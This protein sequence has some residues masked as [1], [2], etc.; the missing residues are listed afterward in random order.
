M[1]ALNDPS[2]VRKR[3]KLALP[4]PVVSE[5]ELE[6]IVKMGYSAAAADA[7]GANGATRNLIGDYRFEFFFFHKVLAIVRLKNF[8]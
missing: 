7:P 3:S 5:R 8:A 2:S 4:A 6:D 1:N